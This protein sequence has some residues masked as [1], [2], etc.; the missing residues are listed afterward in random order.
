MAELPRGTVTLV[1][2][3]IE[4]SPRLLQTL[5]DRYRQAFQQHRTILRDAFTSQAGV[6]GRH[7]GTLA[8]SPSPP[9]RGPSRPRPEDNAPSPNIPGRREASCTS[10]WASTPAR[11][12]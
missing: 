4:G 12:R 1:F 5:G 7:P 10:A 11:R 6:G 3:D 2:T 8:S 9:S